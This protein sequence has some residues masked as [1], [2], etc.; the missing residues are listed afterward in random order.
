MTVKLNVAGEAGE[1]RQKQH[2]PPD[3][4]GQDISTSNPQRPSRG[5]TPVT[6]DREKGF[7]LGAPVPAGE[8]DAPAE[9]CCA[10]S[11]HGTAGKGFFVDILPIP[12]PGRVR[13]GARLVLTRH[14]PARP[15]AARRGPAW[16]DV[17]RPPA[18]HGGNT[19]GGIGSKRFD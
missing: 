1:T 7:V 13:N 6:A 9:V 14:G 3:P 12:R 8:Q 16:H 5:G 15:G 2:T 4:G 10:A 17:T 19:T 18:A 11:A